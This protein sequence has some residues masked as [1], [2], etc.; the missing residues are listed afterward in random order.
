M[1]LKQLK[2]LAIALGVLILA[3]L[4]IEI[5]RDEP[6][7]GITFLTMPNLAQG[8]IDS[9]VITR[10]TNRVSLVAGDAMAWSVNGFR[11]DSGAVAD[12]TDNLVE[13]VRAELVAQNAAS[14]GRFTIGDGEARRLQVYRGGDAM[15]DLL[16]GQRGSD[17][18]SIY[19]RWPDDDDVYLARSQLGTFV[20]R[21]FNDWR[22]KRIAAVPADSIAEVVISGRYTLTRADSGQWDLDGSPADS[23][24]V[25]RLLNQF[26][27]LNASGF[28]T[29]AQMDSV[30]LEEPD[31][32]LLLRNAAR[33][34]LAELSFDSTSA[35]GYWVRRGGDSTVYRLDRFRVDQ[36]VPAD[37]TLRVGT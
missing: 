6:G 9:I 18:Q 3:W 28:P 22:D 5:I 7:D 31:R 30:D 21:P 20:D 16:V 37:S 26:A 17:F 33:D 4:S 34:V 1:S 35:S 36:L 23:A 15:L 10:A 19:V 11:A 27:A 24:A 12:F 8:E 29:S 13:D 14:H 25:A 32:H 2:R